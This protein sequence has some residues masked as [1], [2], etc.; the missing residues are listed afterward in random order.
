MREL[1]AVL[2]TLITV[3]LCGVAWVLCFTVSTF[4]GWLPLALITAG[5][6]LGYGL[7]AAR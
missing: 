5:P 4:G 3:A 7:R 1:T 6:A 2:L